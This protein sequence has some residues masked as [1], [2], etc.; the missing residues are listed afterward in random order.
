MRATSWLSPILESPGNLDGALHL[1]GVG[2]DDTACPAM[3]Q[4]QDFFIVPLTPEADQLPATYCIHGL[5]QPFTTTDV[6]RIPIISV[7]AEG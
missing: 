7:L 2:R 5:D 6:V 1:G 3:E 4:F